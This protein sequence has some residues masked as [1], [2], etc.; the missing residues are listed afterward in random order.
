[1]TGFRC[2]YAW[3]GG[4]SVATDVLIE[5]DGERIATVL[6]DAGTAA[7]DRVRSATRLSGLSLPGLANVHSHAFHRALRGRVHSDRGNFWTW[8]EQMYGIAA[9]LDPE[10]YLRL[11]RAVYTEMV[12]AGITC[13]GE[14]HY[15]HHRPD[16]TPYD[17]PNAMGLALLRAARDAGLRITLLDACY[18]TGNVGAPLTGIQRAFGDGDA[19]QWTAR[20]DRLSAD[21]AVGGGPGTSWARL[22]A[23]VHSVRA[24]PP[25]AAGQV[26]EWASA[27]DVPLHVHVSEQVAENEACKAEYGRTPVRLLSECDVLGPSTTAVHATHVS[28]DDIDSLGATGTAVCFCPTTER[29][30]ADGIGPSRALVDAGCPLTV[31]SDSQAVIDILEEARLVELDQR[32]AT[33][34]RGSFTGSDLLEAATGAGHRALG[35]HDA[36]TLSVGARADLVTVRLDSVRTAG[37][38][39]SPDAAVFAAAA[40]DVHHVVCNGQVVVRDGRH[41]GSDSGVDVGAELAAAIAQVVA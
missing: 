3:L 30:L 11:A 26:A 33:G 10:R 4:P 12:L 32:L 35:W 22:G 16:G 2:E 41:A 20:V 34:V 40:A 29:D 14:F 21:P 39:P 19:K 37:S 7:P 9:R 27:L 23:A 24:V 5:L 6:P 8:R 17:D 36:G 1:M 38:E 15:V 25:H 18:L 28:T 31:G 13:V